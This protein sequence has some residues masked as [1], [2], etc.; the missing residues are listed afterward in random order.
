M[1]MCRNVNVE[2]QKPTRDL[3]EEKVKALISLVASEELEDIFKESELSTDDTAAIHHL[4]EKSI[5]R[6]VQ[7]VYDG[8]IS[9]AEFCNMQR[10]LFRVFGM[11]VHN[12]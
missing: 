2:I 9:T 4:A 7:H 10:Q 11:M 8:A 1:A 3:T 6:L 5:D 12:V